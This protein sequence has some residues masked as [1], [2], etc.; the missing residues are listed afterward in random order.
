MAAHASDCWD[1]K[2]ADGIGEN[3]TLSGGSV[4][5]SYSCN[6]EDRI[7]YRDLLLGT[8]HSDATRFEEYVCNNVGIKPLG[9]DGDT[10]VHPAQAKITA[11]YS[12]SFGGG[13]SEEAPRTSDWSKW[14]ER[15]EGGGEAVTV[16]R[17]FRWSS[18][19]SDAIEKAGAS[20]VKIVP[21]ATITLTGQAGVSTA[22]KTK[23][24]GLFG[25]INASAITIKGHEYAIKKLLFLGA[26][27]DEAD[28]SDAGGKP[29]YDVTYKFAAFF[30]HDFNQFWRD[31]PAFCKTNE[32]KWDEIVAIADSS[33]SVY[34]DVSFTNLDP[35]N[36]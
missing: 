27:L 5:E 36:W 20:S 35:A 9:W 16:G 17:G 25:K 28:G 29:Y 13:E 19:P 24:T 26:D 11:T 3:Y 14:H 1:T 8:A 34:S 31:D 4:T 30:D 22:A 6:W 21:Q 15:W 2:L 23:I 32:P 12:S 10:E 33:K 7:T 18:L